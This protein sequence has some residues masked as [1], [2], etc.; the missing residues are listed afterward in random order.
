M[1]NLFAGLSQYKIQTALAL[2]AVLLISIT[3]VTT[4]SRIAFEYQ[5]EMDS[6]IRQNA[7]LTR[8]FEENVRH[9]LMAIEELLLV[10]KR[11]YETNGAVTPEMIA[12]AQEIKTLPIVHVSIINDK[13]FIIYS[14]L[15]QLVSMDISG[16]EYFQFFRRGDDNKTFFARPI[17]GQDTKQWLF[18]T[19]RRI[20][21]PDGSFGGAINIGVDPK[22]FAGFFRQME[23]GE[24]YAISL[25]GR[26]G[27]VRVRQ[28]KDTTEVGSDVRSSTVYKLLPVAPVGAYT[29][30][31]V[32]DHSRRIYTYR[33]MSDFPFVLSVSVSEMEAL[34]NFYHRRERYIL[35]ASAI[36][37]TIAVV[38]V[39]LI[40]MVTQKLRSEEQ[41]R[42]AHTQLELKVAQRTQELQL[43]NHELHRITSVDGLTSIANRRRFD[44]YIEQE[45]ER[46]LPLTVIMVDI[47][48]FKKYNDTYGHLAG[49][50][51]LKMVAM[52]LA[53]GVTRSQDLVARY[54]GEEFV[55]V[56]PDTA[57]DGG[58]IL[59]EKLRAKVEALG[60]EHRASPYG[61]V[62]ISLGVAA[63]MSAYK[64]P[65]DSLI[66]AADQTLF[67]AKRKGKNR[68]MRAPEQK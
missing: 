7:N 45:G 48:W 17:I 65:V 15:P 9:D 46:A 37:M 10:L 4:D 31:S 64:Q 43:A 55:V 28:T 25:L 67:E 26:D 20:N 49:D 35:I 5:S 21:K 30:L 11:G 61:K 56:L 41:L 50:E 52:T 54:G 57:S 47:D 22:Y 24:E 62:T 14:T 6:I 68:V 53:S 44:A 16:G 27:Y 18:H 51:C 34:A 1:K 58:M 19:S 12:R 29:D 33:A 2:A 60:I 8:A 3:W 42:Q 66:D 39:L 38:F 23:L 59:A 63:T 13:G 40:W 32:S 36:C